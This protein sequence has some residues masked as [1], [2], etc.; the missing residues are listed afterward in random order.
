MVFV[1]ENNALV[2]AHAHR[3]HGRRS[4]CS[5]T[6]PLCIRDAGAASRRQRSRW[7]S[8]RSRRKAVERRRGLAPAERHRGDDRGASPDI[9]SATR[10]VPHRCRS[11]EDRRQ[12]PDSQERARLETLGVA[13]GELD[14]IESSVA[15]RSTTPGTRRSSTRF[16]WTLDRAGARPCLKPS[17]SPSPL[18]RMPPCAEHGR[19]PD[20]LVYGED[21]AIQAGVRGDQG[22][23]RRI[24]RSGLRYADQRER[25]PGLGVGRGGD[26]DAPGRRDHVVG[27]HARRVRP[28]REPG[29]QR[30]LP[31]QG[32][33][34][35]PLTIRMQQG[36]APGACAQHSQSLEALLLHVPGIQVAMPSTPEDAYGVLLSAIW[37]RG[38]D[39]RDREPRCIRGDRQGGPHGGP[40]GTP[41]RAVVARPG[42]DFTPRD[43]GGDAVRRGLQRSAS[44]RPVVRGVEV[45]DARWLAPFG[46]DTVCSSV[47][48]TGKLAV[49]HEATRTWRVRCRGR[50][51]CAGA[52]EAVRRACRCG[53]R[54]PTCVYL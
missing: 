22:G 28:D 16:P 14:E 48:R 39:R 6:R 12:R 13:S 36:M 10:D 18:P 7:R 30:A 15:P 38:S 3:R 29:G 43:M 26:G 46:Y 50:G 41:G 9:T 47:D 21:I 2:G 23:S 49:L 53:S 51:G 37:G 44:S 35:A 34:T 31:L 25:D 4:R 1:C 52:R 40:I 20:V 5:R 8:G 54:H 19:S 32:R 45:I 42:R 17:S 11:P 33:T 24:R 27:F